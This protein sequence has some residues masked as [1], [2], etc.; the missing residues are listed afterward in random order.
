MTGSSEKQTWYIRTAGITPAAPFVGAVTTRPRLAFSS[1]TASAN[2][3]TH[4]STWRNGNGRAR[5][6]AI[7]PSTDGLSSSGRRRRAIPAARRST[8][9]PPGRTPSVWQPR[10]TPVRMTSQMA[11]S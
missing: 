9:S 1:L 6:A 10:K 3:L 4:W 5:M 7:Q 11:R 2:A 8:P